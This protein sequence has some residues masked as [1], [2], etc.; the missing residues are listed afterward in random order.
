MEF[1]KTRAECRLA[2]Q[3]GRRRATDVAQDRFVDVPV[4]RLAD[5]TEPAAAGREMRGQHLR[6][7][8]AACQIRIANDTGAE[9]DLAIQP[10]GAA[11]SDPG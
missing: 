10:A 1:G 5:P 9:P 7:R 2:Q 11:G 4:R 3:V 6:H 8:T